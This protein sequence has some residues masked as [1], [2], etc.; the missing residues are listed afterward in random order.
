M[1]NASILEEEPIFPTTQ[2][3]TYTAQAVLA[4]H[5]LHLKLVRPLNNWPITMNITGTTINN[6]LINHP[7]GTYYKGKLNEHNISCIE[8]FLNWKNDRLLSWQNFQHNIK[9]IIRGRTPKW[10]YQIHELIMSTT[11]PSSELISPNPFTIPPWTPI[12]KGWIITRDK[13]IARIF[14]PHS[15]NHRGKHYVYS[16]LSNRLEPCTG[17]KFKDKKNKTKHCYITLN[18]YRI[19][20]LLVSCKRIIYSDL[21]DIYR[22][23]SFNPPPTPR[24]VQPGP[25]PPRPLSLFEN[26]PA[27]IWESLTS[28]NF[29][30]KRISIQ[31]TTR[32]EK[33]AE[34]KRHTAIGKINTKKDPLHCY[35]LHWPSKTNTLITLLTFII[36]TLDSTTKIDITTNNTLLV[37]TIEY[38]TSLQY[39][40]QQK[41]DGTPFPFILRTLFSLLIDREITITLNKDLTIDNPPPPFP[42]DLTPHKFIYNRF[43]PL[44]MDIPCIQPIKTILKQIHHITNNLKWHNQQRISL[45]DQYLTNGKIQWD[46]TLDTLSYNDKPKGLYTDP[47]ASNLK[48]FK[49]KL[50]AEELPTHL[51][52]HLRNQ[53]KYPNYLCP[54]CYS[55][56]E[57]VP[58][59]LTCISNP[60]NFNT[61][62]KR[63]LIKV[64]TKLE[65]PLYN[66]DGF[67]SSY[68]HLHIQQRLPIGF[69]TNLTLAPFNTN[70]LQTR[71]AP[72]IHHTITEFIYKEIWLPS[73]MS[74]HNDAVP[75]PLPLTTP[76]L[77]PTKPLTSLYIQQKIQL[78][79]TLGHSSLHRL[80]ES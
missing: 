59:L 68:T 1:S 62:L 41:I 8:Q 74:R 18:N 2:F 20:N 40:E 60:F 67:I 21:T 39:F 13:Q 10:F 17:C 38:I 15:T 79:I 73:R 6:I 54:R 53:S 43:T 3:R 23:L 4:L 42:L 77:T 80:L 22:A 5:K 31:L 32:K 25:T 33:I 28:K 29:K 57:D 78:S 51:L 64:A 16:N 72:L 75:C 71:H 70:L 66:V 7:K 52:L 63:I 48:N 34:V 45:W 36:T 26:P 35:N 61:E 14:N 69:I 9:K 65:L 76:T 19:H 55:A 27:T 24:D 11:A 58:H 30:K 37:Q 46:H 49:I 44:L 56:P 12:N 50:L 47:S